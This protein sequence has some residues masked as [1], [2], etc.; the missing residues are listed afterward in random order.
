MSARRFTR[1][2]RAVLYLAADGRC[3][4]TGEPLA[5][6]FHADHIIPY[7]KG[8]PTDVINGAALSP[9][10]NLRKGASVRLPL[11]KWQQEAL[12]LWQ[13]RTEPTFLVHAHTAAGKTG[14][15]AAVI[16]S[17][18]KAHPDSFFV[19]VVPR[20]QLRWQWAD[21]LDRKAGVVFDPTF[22]N[23]RADP[24]PGVLGIVV[25]Y[26]A[27]NSMPERY[28]RLCGKRR[29]VAVLDEVHH[30]GE[31]ENL[32]WGP[33]VSEAFEHASRRL[34]L[35]GTPVRTDGAPLSFLKYEGDP[36]T[37]TPDYAYPYWKGLRDRIVRPIEFCFFDGNARWVQAGELI[38]QGLSELSEDNEGV[39]LKSALEPD[40]QWIAATLPEAARRLTETRRFLPDAGGLIIARDQDH[41]KALA[42]RMGRIIGRHVPYAVSDDN[43]AHKIIERFAAGN[44][45][46]LTAVNLVSEGVDIPRVITLVYATWVRAESAWRQ[47]MGRPIRIRT[48]PAAKYNRLAATVFLP[49]LPTFVRHAHAIEDEQDFARREQ[50]ESRDAGEPRDGEGRE[51]LSADDGWFDRSVLSGQDFSVGETEQ[52]AKLGEQYGVIGT[53]AQLAQLLRAKTPPSEP[54]LEREPPTAWRTTKQLRDDVNKLARLRAIQNGGSDEAYA[55]VYKSLFKR[56]DGVWSVDQASDEVLRRWI[57]WLS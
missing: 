31:R 3:E 35:T 51:A 39:A 34:L 27:V 21:E 57:T 16:D 10:S 5:N 9:S 22:D 33:K 24:R 32:S 1:R 45:P 37:A 20:K 49:E 46:W 56:S 6:G 18:R 19:V 23:S 54:R 55:A 13:E 42:T 29:V 17:E 2:Q 48:G 15:A 8:G 4:E 26:Q 25:T 53:P 43:D 44:E 30:C 38:E 52:A 28:R 12:A 47:A 36:P 41:A 40:S 14:L 11:R 7:S 50:G